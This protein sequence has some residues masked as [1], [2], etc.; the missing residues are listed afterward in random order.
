MLAI[1]TILL[2]YFLSL[3]ATFKC[4][5]KIQSGLGVD[6]L[7]YLLTILLNSPLEK[8]IHIDISFDGISSK[9]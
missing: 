7:L 8:D 6:E 3:I 2:R 1:L 9:T 4:F 5:H